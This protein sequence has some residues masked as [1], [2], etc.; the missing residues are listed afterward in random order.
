MSQSFESIRHLQA[1]ALVR[2]EVREIREGK[3]VPEVKQRHAEHDSAPG[4][5]ER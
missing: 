1:T 3:A 4:E 5:K 2:D